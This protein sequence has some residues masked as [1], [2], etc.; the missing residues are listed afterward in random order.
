MVYLLLADGFE[1]A[2]ALVTADLLRRGG[3]SV[4]LTGVKHLQVTGA[5]LI[6]VTADL[7]VDQADPG[8]MELVILPGGLGGVKGIRSSTAAMGLIRTAVVQGTPVAAICAAPTVLAGLGLLD[9]RKAVCYP[10]MEH[11]MGKAEMQLGAPVVTD[12]PFI[13]GEAAGSV[14]DF[15]LKLVELLKGS[16]AAEEVRHAVHYRR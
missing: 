13:T 2:E 16:A 7:T 11:E 8:D 9:G 6:T 1:E 14:F 5:H 12:G 10:G 15:G 3:C 4:A